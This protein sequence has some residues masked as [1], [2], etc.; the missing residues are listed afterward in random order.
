MVEVEDPGTENRMRNE[1]SNGVPSCAVD[2][3]PVRPLQCPTQVEYA[4][5]RM[6][7]CHPN[8]STLWGVRKV[9]RPKDGL[10]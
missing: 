8:T 1:A 3:Q 10:Q 2:I 6:V 5:E 4:L 9:D 7:C